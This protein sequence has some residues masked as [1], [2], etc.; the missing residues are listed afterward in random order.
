MMLMMVGVLVIRVRL[1]SIGLGPHFT[2]DEQDAQVLYKIK[3]I[4]YTGKIA[5]ETIFRA[6]LARR[7]LKWRLF[8]IVPVNQQFLALVEPCAAATTSGQ[9]CLL[10]SKVNQ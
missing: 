3:T 1:L 2:T 7:L 4:C 9:G 8:L 10:F 5:E 6:E